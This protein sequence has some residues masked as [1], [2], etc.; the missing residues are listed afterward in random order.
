MRCQFDSSDVSIVDVNRM[1]RHFIPITIIC[2]TISIFEDRV[3]DFIISSIS[4]LP[5]LLILV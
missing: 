1:S 5:W 4:Y 3:M 2:C